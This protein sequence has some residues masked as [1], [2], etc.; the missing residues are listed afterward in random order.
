[1]TSMSVYVVCDK[2]KLET[3]AK[4][5]DILHLKYNSHKYINIYIYTF[6]VSI[7]D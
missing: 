6:I 1:M 5:F 2:S 7:T 3:K 4:L